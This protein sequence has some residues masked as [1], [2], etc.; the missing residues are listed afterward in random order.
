MLLAFVVSMLLMAG[1]WNPARGLRQISGSC[2]YCWRPRPSLSLSVLLVSAVAALETSVPIM[3]RF[4]SDLVEEPRAELAAHTALVTVG[5][6]AAL[7][8]SVHPWALILMWIPVAAIYV[9]LQQQHRVRQEAERA[10]M[11]S[12]AALVKAQRLA[13]VGSWEWLAA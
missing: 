6:L 13:Q 9:T 4:R 11:L 2:S 3:A 12:D 1:G 8:A 7:N 5:F 10:R